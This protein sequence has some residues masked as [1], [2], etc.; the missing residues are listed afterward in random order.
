M[1]H[2]NTKN[3]KIHQV[4]KGR[5]NSFLIQNDNTYILVDT[6]NEKSWDKL[7]HNIDGLLDGNALS[8]LILTHSHF[9]HAENAAKIKE[10][11]TSQILIHRNEAESL[12]I[13][14][15]SIPKGTNLATKFLVDKIGVRIESRYKYYPVH[16]DILVDEQ[17]DLMKVGFKAYTLHTPGH[18]NGSISIII[19]DSIAIVGDTLFGVIK[20]SVY[21]PFADDPQEIVQSWEKLLNTGCSLFLPGHGK[22]ISR[23][24]LKKQYFIRKASPK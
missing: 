24:V 22:E 4:L 14:Y 7:K 9:D 6:G 3:I 18:S 5:S 20:N 1:K 13:G 23:N 10:K 2:W 15:K 19:E 12:N 17:Y 21:P 8:Y 11:Y 16:P